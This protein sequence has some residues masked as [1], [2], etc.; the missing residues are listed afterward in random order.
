MPAF[1]HISLDHLTDSQ[2]RGVGLVSMAWS[3]LEG[4]VER[5]TWLSG[6]F[7]EKRALAV[8]TH[9]SINARLDA[10][11]SIVDLEFPGSKAANDLSKITKHIR[12]NLAPRRNEIVHSRLH[13]IGDTGATFRTTYKA[14][15]KV[16]TDTK[17]SEL[18]E[19]E[20]AARK[21]LDTTNK[22]MDI[23]NDLYEMVIQK[24]GVQPPWPHRPAPQD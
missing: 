7:Q 11:L 17:L 1:S 2:L 12:Q 16:K 13:G 3:Y 6:R 5:I 14:R 9:M 19:Y 21:I 10:M 8:T 24:D 4:A 23:M 18:E 15:G 22:L 20:D